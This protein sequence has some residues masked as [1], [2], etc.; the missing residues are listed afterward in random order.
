M[1]YALLL[2]LH[3]LLAGCWLGGGL[4]VFHIAGRLADPVQPLSVRLLSARAMLLLELIPRGCLVLAFGSGISL[5]TQM[6]LLPLDGWLWLVWGI[7]VLWMGLTWFALLNEHS[8]LGQSC[9][10]IDS[11]LHLLVLAAC[12]AAAIDA[13]HDG[14]FIPQVRWLAAKLLLFAG[15]ISLGLLV[16]IQLKPFAPLFAKV[17]STTAS[18]A[19]QQALLQRVD[20]VKIPVLLTWTFIIVI[21]AFGKLKLI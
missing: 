12:V 13:F 10:R 11:G 3:L 20:R 21:A 16:R 1:E 17:T 15:I 19:E 7:S 9:A 4:G 6:G 8:P 2:L 18:D 14:G 5:A